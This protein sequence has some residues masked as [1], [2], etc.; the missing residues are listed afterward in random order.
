M[1]IIVNL[2]GTKS[3][4][5]LQTLI[6]LSIFALVIALLYQGE[7]ST[8]DIIMPAL[9]KD[10]I[11]PI[12]S[13]LAVMFWCFVGIEAFAHMGEEFK[14]PERDFPLAIIIGCFIG[15]ATYWACS[16]VI[17]KYGAYGSAYFETAS[18]PWLSEQLFGE[19]FGLLISVLG[20]AACFASIN[21]YTQSLSRMVW[22]QARQYRLKVSLQ[23]SV[24]EAFLLTPR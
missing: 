6:A 4:G 12:A 14:N 17:L 24:S 8:A 20:F 2:L 7:V 1:L 5:R 22:A 23:K 18:I 15:G 21:L 13:A 19:K 16:V 11:W 9:T 3:S 10:A